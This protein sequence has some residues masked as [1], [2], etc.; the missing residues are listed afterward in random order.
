MIEYGKLCDKIIETTR[1]DGNK[2]VPYMNHTDKKIQKIAYKEEMMNALMSHN[3]K[4]GKSYYVWYVNYYNKEIKVISKRA[5]LSNK[6]VVL[7]RLIKP[8]HVV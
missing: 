1:A 8:H 6:K 5:A 4:H 7:D 2:D 3:N